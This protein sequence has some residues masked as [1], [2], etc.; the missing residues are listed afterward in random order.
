M[1]GG[2]RLDTRG[3][4]LCGVLGTPPTGTPA[5]RRGP[6]TTAEEERAQVGAAL[7]GVSVL[8]GKGCPGGCGQGGPAPTPQGAYLHVPKDG[9]G[10]LRL[11]FL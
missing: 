3:S 11:L 10:P 8:A 2:N 9:R 4:L 1:A 7:E 5:P 6:A